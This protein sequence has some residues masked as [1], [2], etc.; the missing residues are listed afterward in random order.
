[1]AIQ[2]RKTKSPLPPFEEFEERF[3][4]AFGRD[5]TREERRFYRLTNIV[6]EEDFVDGL[7]EALELLQVEEDFGRGS[8]SA[9]QRLMD[10][11]AGVGQGVT[12]ALGA[13]GQ[14]DGP[15]A[16]RLADAVG[17]HVARHVLHRVVD[18]QPGRDGPSGGI[19][20]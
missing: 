6:L 19:N 18:A 16:R 15:H 20:V 10:H 14:E 1:M 13:G 17:R 2:R 3:R 7:L 8:L 4:Q 5:M 11:D 9:G 12:L